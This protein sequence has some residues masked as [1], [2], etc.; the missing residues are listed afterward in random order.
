MF[1]R[2]K[3]V[4]AQVKVNGFK[5]EAVDEREW[6]LLFKFIKENNFVINSDTSWRKFSS[7]L[8]E[9]FAWAAGVK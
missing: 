1:A 8:S 3:M 6:W 2:G 5:Q 4:L 7:K 9:S